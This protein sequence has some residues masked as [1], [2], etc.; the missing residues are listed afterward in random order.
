MIILVIIGTNTN[1][2][3]IFIPSLVDVAQS[4]YN[5]SFA[6]ESFVSAFAVDLPAGSAEQ[7]LALYPLSS[8]NNS[9]V[10]AAAEIFADLAFVCPMLNLSKAMTSTGVPVYRYRFNQLLQEASSIWARD[11]VYVIL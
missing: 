8:Y 11:G 7:V 1:D 4:V 10:A 6:L 3:T 5:A 9:A 2:G